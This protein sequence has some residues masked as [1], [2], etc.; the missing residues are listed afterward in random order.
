MTLALILEIVQ[1]LAIAI[2]VTLAGLFGL[3]VLSF[4]LDER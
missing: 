3:L 2:A 1:T 4:L